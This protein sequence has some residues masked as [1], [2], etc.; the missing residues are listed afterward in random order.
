MVN[1]FSGS[2]ITRVAQAVISGIGFLGAG[3]IIVTREAKVTGITTAASIWA[4]ACLGVAI[5][6]GFY[7]GALAGSI[8]IFIIMIVLKNLDF[9]IKEKANDHAI[10]VEYQDFSY[11]RRLINKLKARNIII[12]KVNIISEVENED[13]VPSAIITFYIAEDYSESSILEIIK[14]S[15]G[16]LDL[17]LLNN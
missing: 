11:H 8:G 7:I 3:A 15:K 1:K 12:S 16:I 17:E 9:K 6:L 10:Y 4:A 2:D 5:G 13:N 14:K